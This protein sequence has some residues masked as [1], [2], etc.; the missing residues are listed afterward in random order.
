MNSEQFIRL[1]QWAFYNAN[2][3]KYTGPDD[4]E[5]MKLNRVFTDQSEMDGYYSGNNTDWQDLIYQNGMTTNHQI[6]INGEE[7]VPLTTGLWGI[8]K[9]KIISRLILLSV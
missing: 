7:T 2:S 6:S 9:A 4:P 8:I 1:K 3:D 5:I